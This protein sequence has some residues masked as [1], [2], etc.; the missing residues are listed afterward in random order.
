MLELVRIMGEVIEDGESGPDSGKSGNW[1]RF[2]GCWALSVEQSEGAGVRLLDV[3]ESLCLRLLP[4]DVTLRLSFSFL[5]MRAGRPWLS[6]STGML[7]GINSP[8]G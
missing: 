4:L 5:R 2:M 6:Y 8:E 7:K 1:S 3:D